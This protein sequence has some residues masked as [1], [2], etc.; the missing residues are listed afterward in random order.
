MQGILKAGN[1]RYRKHWHLQLM[2]MVALLVLF[3]HDLGYGQSRTDSVPLY[4]SRYQGSKTLS[5]QVRYLSLLAK[6]MSFQHRDPDSILQYVTL[7][8]QRIPKLAEKERPRYYLITEQVSSEAYFLKK[9]Y[10]VAY[11]HVIRSL[12]LARQT[13][14]KK[15]EADGSFIAML[16][17]TSL[18]DTRNAA[19]YVDDYVRLKN[20]PN[21]G[22]DKE[23]IY[24][25]TWTFALIYRAVDDKKNAEQY[26]S[27]LL[28][29][30][31]Q[32]ND[33]PSIV[34][35]YA[36]RSGLYLDSSSLP[37]AEAL[38]DTAYSYAHHDLKRYP[39]L[40]HYKIDLLYAQRKFADLISLLQESGRSDPLKISIGFN[41]FLGL[42]YLEQA[43][44][45]TP[46]DVVLL[47]KALSYLQQASRM[48]FDRDMIQS[49]STINKPEIWRSL[50][51][52]QE[53]L[54]K[55]SDALKSYKNF[56]AVKDSLYGTERKNEVLRMGLEYETGKYLDS[57]AGKE[58]EA[59]L[60]QKIRIGKS[61]NVRN[62]A[63]TTSV[64]MALLL[65]ITGYAFIRKRRDNREI[66]EEKRKSDRL[67]LN[68]LP[69]SVAAELKEHGN[70]EAREYEEVTVLFTDFVN[71]TKISEQLTPQQLVAEL[72]A[73]FKGFDAIVE[74]YNLEKIKTIGDAYLAVSGLPAYHPQHAVNAVAAAKEIIEFVQQRESSTTFEIR[75]GMHTG[76]L[77]A[78]IV[79]V[80]K[81]AY[82]IWGDTVNI[83]SRMESNSLPGRINISEHTYRLVKDTYECSYR[84]KVSAKNKGEM[85]MYF[86]V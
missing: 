58:K 85:D 18:G 44:K 15:A 34:N 31:R 9:S 57:L 36:S 48:D 21:Q 16:I 52:T 54:G 53:Y 35:I 55:Y 30:N 61:E 86:V 47:H 67:L 69:E 20:R 66:A 29:F 56:L 19:K 74:K 43:K 2:G 82:D 78:G 71:F 24:S 12:R 60:Q 27:K 62:L 80:K 5:D 32:R 79:G 11:N 40:I 64:A 77:V 14:D 38:L 26:F 51:E 4:Y 6:Y 8:E 22:L 59:L 41:T 13:G 63:L 46:P 42:S 45:T 3:C 37:K 23:E 81:F 83:A 84:G 65:S 72:H 1:K 17:L 75:I 39:G 76:P 50:A 68:I 49:E 25:D 73:C 7:M 28:Q 70:S 10:P 33:T